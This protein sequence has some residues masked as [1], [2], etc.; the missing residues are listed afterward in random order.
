MY[1]LSEDLKYQLKEFVTESLVQD[2]NR[3][4]VNTRRTAFFILKV[5]VSDE[6][7]H[8]FAYAKLPR[9][10]KMLIK[11]KSNEVPFVSDCYNQNFPETG[12]TCSELFSGNICRFYVNVLTL[13]FK[14][15]S[16]CRTTAR[17]LETLQD[18]KRIMERS[19]RF[20]SLSG[21]S[22]ISA[23]ICALIGAGFAQKSIQKYYSVEYLR[24]TAYPF[25]LRIDLTLIAIFTFAS[26]LVLATFF[27]YLKS[28][29]EGVAIWGSTARRLL[30]N[31]LL[32]MLVGG[33]F[34][35][36]LIDL[37]EYQLL[38]PAALIF[39]GL[40]L[41]NGSKYTMG[42][43]RW[44][45]YGE[46]FLGIV[47]LWVLHEEILFWS[48]GFGILHIIYGIAMWWKY[49]RSHQ[50]DGRRMAHEVNAD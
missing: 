26:A 28:R 1:K 2:K 50:T 42:E 39:Y 22:G 40:A 10:F 21:W 38:A 29:K 33:F 44:L 37:K 12:K 19:S 9:H 14:V 46:I 35:W 25:M 18:I 11:R 23:G 49:D 7:N 20:I 4:I 47:N 48:L 45:G 43:V 27:T 34:I 13:S 16:I 8:F 6:N 15:L 24:N 30:W 31:T 17:D 32:P 3:A 36:R 5:S 41:V